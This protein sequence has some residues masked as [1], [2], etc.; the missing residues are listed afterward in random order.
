MLRYGE[1]EGKVLRYGRERGSEVLRYG[2]GYGG[3][4]C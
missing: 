1:E 3:L 2:K 4:R